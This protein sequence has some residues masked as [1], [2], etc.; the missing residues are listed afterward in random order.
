[1]FEIMLSNIKKLFPKNILALLRSD[2]STGQFPELLHKMSKGD[3]SEN[4]F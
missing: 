1:M 3:Y 2:I 4:I